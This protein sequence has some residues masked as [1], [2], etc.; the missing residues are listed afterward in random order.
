VPVT[1]MG[2][3]KK[4]REGKPATI[5]KGKR[6]GGTPFSGAGQK[7]SGVCCH[8]SGKRRRKLF[9]RTR[10]K[11]ESLHKY[12]G[13]KQLLREFKRPIN[14]EGKKGKKRDRWNPA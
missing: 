14:R 13:G 12:S 8:D 3:K 1:I 10:G 5:K 7:K 4:H 11:K 9:V 2:K 6:K